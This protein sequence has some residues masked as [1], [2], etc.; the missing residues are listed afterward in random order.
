MFGY[1]NHSANEVVLALG[2]NQEQRRC[3]IAHETQHVLRGPV[4]RHLVAREEARADREAARLLLP[5]IKAVAEALAWS[6]RN[7]AEAA[8]EL[9]VD[10]WMLRCRLNNMHPSEKHYLNGR[11]RGL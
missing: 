6:N 9:W 11:L 5:D 10:E 3:T 2:L 8:D 4:P 1:T 7:I